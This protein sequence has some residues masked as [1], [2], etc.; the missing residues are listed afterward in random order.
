VAGSGTNNICSG[1]F[2]AKNW[3]VTAAH[4]LALTS[5]VS[6]PLSQVVAGDIYGDASWKVEWPDGSGTL[7]TSATL[8]SQE[9][10]VLQNP[11]PRYMGT[12]PVAS[13]EPAFSHYDFAL[14]YFPEDT[15]DG[16]LPP[17]ADT[18]AAMR[19]SIVPPDPNAVMMAAGFGP[20]DSG[21]TPRL[22]RGAFQPPFFVSTPGDFFQKTVQT[23]T[24]PV[25]CHGDSGGPA[26]TMVDIGPITQPD[27]VPVE[28]APTTVPVMFGVNS[29]LQQPPACFQTNPPSDDCPLPSNCA[30][31]NGLEI[32]K[33]V[34]I[35]ERA[36]MEERM[37]LWQYGPSFACR[38]GH[39]TGASSNTFIECWG[40]PCES[41]G[42]CNQSNNE[43]CRRDSLALQNESCQI[44]QGSCD[45][46]VGQCVVGP[47]LS[48]NP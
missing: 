19:L 39:A 23:V 9:E 20:G 14:L 29:Q 48:A 37:G 3:L 12:L 17:R 45:C 40:T 2:I 13:G 30:Q 44:C 6:I 32:W 4:C 22:Q 31:Q 33:R 34:D 11:D 7:S 5:P 25:L 38:E 10:D 16:V 35:D 8:T 15:Y 26:Y 36:F 28:Q 47:P 27:D 42:D 41:D 18:G 1:T 24:E 43:Y 21:G 46:I